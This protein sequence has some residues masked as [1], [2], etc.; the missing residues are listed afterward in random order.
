MHKRHVI[1]PRDMMP[2]HTQITF[3]PVEP[4]TGDSGTKWLLMVHL[5]DICSIGLD[6]CPTGDQREGE[7][8]RLEA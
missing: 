3:T 7:F 1:Q 6:I 5:P 4:P 2:V 8:P